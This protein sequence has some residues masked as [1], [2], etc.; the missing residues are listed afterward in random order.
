M[1][2]LFVNYVVNQTIKKYLK[3]GGPTSKWG[4]H[5]F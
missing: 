2:K 5:A 4:G 3:N 1:I